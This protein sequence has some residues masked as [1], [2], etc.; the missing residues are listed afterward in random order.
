MSNLEPIELKDP[1]LLK[2]KA[3]LAGEWQDAQSGATFEVRNT[4]TGQVLA[5][6]PRMGAAETRR[7]IEAANLAWP[8]WRVQPA[9][10]RAAILRKWYEL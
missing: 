9:K 3:F 4:A 6:V 1:S 10:A 2:T 7:A 8:A 5:A